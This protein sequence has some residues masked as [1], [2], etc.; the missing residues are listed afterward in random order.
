L[1]PVSM[2][3]ILAPLMVSAHAIAQERN[4]TLHVTSSDTLP[5]VWAD[6]KALRE[7]LNNLLDN[8]LKYTPPG[9]DVYVIVGIDGNESIYPGKQGIAIADTGPGIPPE[10]QPHLFTRHFRGVQAQ[11]NIPGTGL[12]LAIAQLLMH[13]MQ[14]EISVFSP[15]STCPIP[16]SLDLE[17]PNSSDQDLGQNAGRESSQNSSQPIAESLASLRDKS[18]LVD[19]Q[20]DYMSNDVAVKNHCQRTPLKAGASTDQFLGSLFIVWMADHLPSAGGGSPL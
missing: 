5:L 16:F 2:I 17:L 3:D 8:A 19:R 4:L 12:G 13:Q 20:R 7:V 10:D 11:G 6:A 1:D 14:G 18:S 9:G 15:I